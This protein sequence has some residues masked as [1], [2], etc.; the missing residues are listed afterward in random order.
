MKRKTKTRFWI[1]ELLISQTY[2]RQPLVGQFFNKIRL[3]QLIYLNRKV[4]IKIQQILKHFIKETYY[5][6]KQIKTEL[7]NYDFFKTEN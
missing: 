3:I 6:K 4:L 2:W 7:L 5:K 1:Q